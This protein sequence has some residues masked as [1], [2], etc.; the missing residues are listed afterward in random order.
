[1]EKSRHVH[2]FEFGNSDTRR[3]LRTFTFT[4]INSRLRS[5]RYWIVYSVLCWY[6]G[7]FN[8]CLESHSLVFLRPAC[9][10]SSSKY[11]TTQTQTN[12]LGSTH[13][14]AEIKQRTLSSKSRNEECALWTQHRYISK[15]NERRIGMSGNFV[16][17]RITNYMVSSLPAAT[18]YGYVHS[19]RNQCGI[20]CVLKHLQQIH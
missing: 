20:F 5:L 11:T 10:G 3:C 19:I 9:I 2:S 13:G 6:C 7:H 1:M 18:S 8:I 17:R 4:H 12:L 14:R 15:T 16:E